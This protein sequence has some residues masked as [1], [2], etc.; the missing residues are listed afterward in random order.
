M[1]YLQ[2]LGNENRVI[3]KVTSL[4]NGQVAGPITGV[5]GVYLV[6]VIHRTEASL[7]TD[8]SSFR[9]QLTATSR[10]GV[11]SRLIE[12][13]RSTADIEDFRYNFY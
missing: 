2:G 7:S 6:Q 8:I 11:D 5:S 9:G 12:A 4:S 1:S 3:G 10:N 13:I